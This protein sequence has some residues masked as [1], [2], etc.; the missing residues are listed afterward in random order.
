MPASAGY[1]GLSYTYVLLAA[2]ARVEL[3]IDRPEQRANKGLFD[4][5]L[6]Q[7]GRIERSFGQPLEWQ[8]LDRGRA[9]RIS[10]AIHVGGW[11]DSRT[12]PGLEQALLD[13]MTRLERAMQERL[14]EQHARKQAPPGSGTPPPAA[15]WCSTCKKKVVPAGD[16]RCG[17]C[18]K[19]TGGSVLS[20]LF[21][22][23]R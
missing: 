13:A 23:K 22:K 12:W 21:T 19:P 3:Y 5:L 1:P 4:S 15:A 7:K 18:G 10:C 8:R 2:A 6:A 11:K 14:D 16:G 9:C 17:T 20:G